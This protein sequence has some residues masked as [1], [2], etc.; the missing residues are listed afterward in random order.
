MS[1]PPIFI[2]ALGFVVLCALSTSP[3]ADPP[4]D[5]A[6]SLIQLIANAGAFDGKRVLVT[7]YVVLEFENTAVYL[8]E[9]D[10]T[11]G[12]ARNGLWLDVPLGGDSHRTRFHQRYVLIEGTFNAH[13]RGHLGL[14][15]G[16]IE[17]IGRFELVEPRPGPLRPAPH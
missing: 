16:S 6:V 13:R 2:V 11:Y 9:S 1:G 10:A 7:G 12:I 8:H 3:H 4:R 14:F 17:S 5:T 15:S